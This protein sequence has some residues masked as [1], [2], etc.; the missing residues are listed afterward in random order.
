MVLRMKNFGAL[1]GF[2]GSLKDLTSRGDHKKTNIEGG[3]PKKGELGQFA[4]LRV[5]LGKK[6]GG[7][8]FCRGMGCT[9]WLWNHLRDLQILRLISGEFNRIN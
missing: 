6:W 7:G 9:L 8:V 2:G 4:D 3:L 1:G 5:G